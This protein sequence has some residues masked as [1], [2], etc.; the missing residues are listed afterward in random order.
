MERTPIHRR[1]WICR[2]R[3]GRSGE[4]TRAATWRMAWSVTKAGG[5]LVSTTI[6]AVERMR[7]RVTPLPLYG[8]RPAPETGLG[9]RRA[10]VG[11]RVV[12][13]RDGLGVPAWLHSRLPVWGNPGPAVGWNGGRRGRVGF[14]DAGG[15]EQVMPFL[16]HRCVAGSADQRE[17]HRR[18][19]HGDCRKDVVQQKGSPALACVVVAQISGSRTISGADR[20][21]TGRAC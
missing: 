9:V 16:D 15:S 19:K 10:P 13:S 11:P 17:A 20:R 3:R 5:S 14:Q 4:S 7:I 6:G 8:G 21:P 12:L 1:R 18:Q 2:Q